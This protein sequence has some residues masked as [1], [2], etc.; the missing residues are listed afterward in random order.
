MGKNKKVKPCIPISAPPY[1]RKKQ[2][3]ELAE[4]MRE[5][6]LIV[7]DLEKTYNRVGIILKGF[8]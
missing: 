3:K 4:Q 1:Y 8:I 5:S 2:I 6:Q 7:N